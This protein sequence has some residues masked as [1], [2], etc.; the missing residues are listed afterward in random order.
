[1]IKQTRISDFFKFKLDSENYNEINVDTNIE[2]LNN[3]NSYNFNNKTL[4]K[5]IKDYFNINSDINNEKACETNTNDLLKCNEKRIEIYTDGSSYNNGKKNCRASWAYNIYEDDI[6]LYKEC[7]KCSE[8]NNKQSN[9]IAELLGIYKSLLKCYQIYQLN[10]QQQ[11]ITKIYIYSDSMYSIKCINEWSNKWSEQDWNKKKN[12]DIIK[13]IKNIINQCKFEIIF[14]H[15]LSHQNKSLNK[16][17]IRNN[18]VDKEAKKINS[19]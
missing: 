8:Y 16:H 10:K 2:L 15:I 13:N 14:I 19:F 1:M 7:G 12:T 6:C 4:K 18:I 17:H 11:Y 5:S 3:E 9:Q